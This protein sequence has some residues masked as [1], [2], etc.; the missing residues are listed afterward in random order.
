MVRAAHGNSPD[1]SPRFDVQVGLLPVPGP[2][3]ASSQPS[4]MASSARFSLWPAGIRIAYVNLMYGL[5]IRERK[6]LERYA[7]WRHLEFRALEV[8]P[9]D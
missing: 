9:M 2:S 8:R 5:A 6:W 7:F 1:R 3:A 4:G